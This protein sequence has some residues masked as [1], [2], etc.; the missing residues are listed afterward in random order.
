M[1]GEGGCGDIGPDW[2]RKETMFKQ[3]KNL[4]YLSYYKFHSTGL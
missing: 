2:K 3:F 4:I 1:G